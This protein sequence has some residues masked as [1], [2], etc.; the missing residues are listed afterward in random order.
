MQISEL[1]NKELQLTEQLAYIYSNS[2]WLS[3]YRVDYQ[4]IS[5]AKITKTVFLWLHMWVLVI[6]VTEGTRIRL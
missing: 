2:H 6:N 1:S 3:S 4:E 5:K